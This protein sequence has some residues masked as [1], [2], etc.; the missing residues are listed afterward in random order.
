M[1]DAGT[2]NTIVSLALSGPRPCGSTTSTVI[3]ITCCSLR[4]AQWHRNHGITVAASGRCN[5]HMLDRRRHAA[6]Y[7]EPERSD[8]LE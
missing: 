6:N 5:D 1:K 2:T 7:D 3:S 8:H 4:R